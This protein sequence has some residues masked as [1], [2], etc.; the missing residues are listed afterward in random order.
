MDPMSNCRTV[1][2]RPWLAVAVVV[3][4]AAD[5]ASPARLRAQ[6]AERPRLVVAVVVDQLRADLVDRYQSLWDQDASQDDAGS[7]FTRLLQDGFRFTQASHAHA[8]TSTAPGHATLATGVFPSR[9]GVVA[10]GWSQ[11]VGAEWTAMYA[12]ADPESPILGFEN[13]PALEGRSPETLLRDGLAD[14]LLSSD[15]DARVVS[16]SMKDRS[17]VTL[18]GRTTEHVY[19]ILPELGRFITSRHYMSRYPRWLERFNEEVMPSITEPDVWDTEVPL[20]AQVLARPDS[21]AY[22]GDGVHTT[23][24]HRSSEA[25]PPDSWQARNVWAYDQ[26]RAD[27]AVIQLA[28]RAIDELDLGQ[29]DRQDM[30]LIS[31][32]A[33][34]RVGHAYGP[35]S[36]EQLSNLIHLD[37]L[38]GDLLAHLDRTVGE[39]RWVLGLSADHGVVTIPEAQVEL[40]I[41][42]DAR[43]WLEEERFRE[44]ADVLRSVAGEGGTPD[45]LAERLA[46]GVED[47]GLVARAYTHHGLTTGEPA[48]SFAVLFRNSYHPGRAWGPLSRW[49]VDVRFGEDDLVGPPTGTNHESTYWY[50][51]WVPMIFLGAGVEPGSSDEPVRTVDFAPTLAGLAGMDVPSDLDGRRIN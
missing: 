13:E 29:D 43:R 16:I 32:S 36:Q 1:G 34:D 22:E 26:P 49:G 12:V 50:D 28:Y 8:R 38:L 3:T 24:P 5:V 51:R 27:D 25:Y 35:L 40:G 47:A 2:R 46:R 11:L 33:T 4:L 37:R 39:G 10:N 45:E 6:D 23:F 30:L 20:D 19:W 21:A 17:A 14:W 15:P 48:D 7:G 44:M 18:G 42:P 41:H 9:H 31:L